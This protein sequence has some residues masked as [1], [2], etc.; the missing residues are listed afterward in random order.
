MGAL[1][2]MQVMPCWLIYRWSHR[3]SSV[4]RRF[5]KNLAKQNP[6]YPGQTPPANDAAGGKPSIAVLPFINL[7]GDS[8][9]EYF[10][11][12]ITEEIITA[13][14]RVGWIFVIARHSSFAY[15][16]RQM[17]IR[18]VASELGV[19][20]IVEGSVRKSGARTRVAAQLVEGRS[21]KHV[22]A[23]RYDRENRDVFDLQD[24]IAETIVGAIEPELGKVECELAESK[25]PENLQAWDLYQRGM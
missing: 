7:S 18:E 15:K 14:S 20:Y 25:P 2:T 19:Q 4:P 12:G 13:L 9:E 23:K 11:D 16:D 3:R 1:F 6:P 5:K 10:V 24:E 8:G 22:W 21:G 17:D